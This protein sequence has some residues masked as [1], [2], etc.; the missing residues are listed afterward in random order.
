MIRTHPTWRDTTESSGSSGPEP[1]TSSVDPPPMSRIR[2]GPSS[3][4]R[5]ET[6]PAIDSRP[7]SVP[8]NSSG[9]MPVTSPA[10]RRNSSP[11]EASRAADVA[12]NLPL[13]TEHLSMTCRYSRSTARQRR[14]ASGAS[15]PVASTPAPNRVICMERSSV[16]PSS[17]TISSRVELVPQSMAATGPTCSISPCYHGGPGGTTL[18]ATTLAATTVVL[19]G[20]PS[21]LPRWSQWDHPGRGPVCRPSARPDRTPPGPDRHRRSRHRAARYRLPLRRDDRTVQELRPLRHDVEGVVPVPRDRAYRLAGWAFAFLVVVT[22]ILLVAGVVVTWLG[23][24]GPDQ[25]LH[26]APAA[27]AAGPAA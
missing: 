4:S 27:H 21:R 10:D 15:M 5:S 22:L 12:A 9:S 2:N 17:S 1:D 7:S 20:P 23:Q 16:V 25:P 24:P 6:A 14:T 18:A 11:L 3:G 26:R 19:V 8:S 13:V